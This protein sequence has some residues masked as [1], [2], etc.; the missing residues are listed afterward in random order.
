MQIDKIIDGYVINLEHN[1]ERK[2]YIINEF[3]NSPIQ[4]KFFKAIKN[5]V[6]WVG[7]LKSHLSLIKFAKENNM[8]MILVIEDDTHIENKETFNKT[9][10]QIIEYLKANMNNWKIFNGGPNV[11]KHSCISN[12]QM[13]NP[14]LFDVS[15][16]V[17]ANFI[18]YNSNCYDFF[19]EF[20]DYPIN[21]LKSSHKIDMLIF[22]KLITTTTYPCLV[23][24]INSYSDILKFVRNDFQ[25]MKINQNRI[26]KRK[27]KNIFPSIQF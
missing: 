22:N 5:N 2:N 7:C 10:I 27:L 18:I 15:K 26:M 8:D 17:L 24:Q 23:W 12:I 1:I 6:G 3:Q 14:L 25:I 11:N 20:Y 4:L 16:C 21:K 19:L 13:Q 9:F